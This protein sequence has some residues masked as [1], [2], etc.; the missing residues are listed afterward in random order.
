M[1]PFLSRVFQSVLGTLVSVRGREAQFEPRIRCLEPG[2]AGDVAVVIPE[3]DPPIE[4]QQRLRHLDVEPT[5]D[6]TILDLIQ[7]IDLGDVVPLKEFDW[8]DGLVW[9][10][11]LAQPIEDALQGAG[12]EVGD[13]EGA[14]LH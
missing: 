10:L 5:I 13:Q 3:N 6:V 14:M 4:L 2:E 7:S 8:I 9:A 11:V 12:L 1:R